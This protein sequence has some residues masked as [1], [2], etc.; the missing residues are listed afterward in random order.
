MLVIHEPMNTS[1]ILSPA[2]SAKV[3]ASSGSFG[4]QRIGSLMALISIVMSAAY[5]A[6]AS[7]RNN[8][9]LASHASIPLIRRAMVRASP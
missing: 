2:T 9:G 8:V 3:L 1:S 6:S 5:S 7:A 4:Q